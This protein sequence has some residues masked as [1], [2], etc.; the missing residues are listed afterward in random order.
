M[1]I[2]SI[3]DINL[4]EFQITDLSE[5]ERG[6]FHALNKL[7]KGSCFTI[8]RVST[9]NGLTGFYEKPEKARI[10]NPNLITISTVTG[11]AFLQ[12]Y[13][14]IAT[15]NVIICIPKNPLSVTSLIYIQTSINTVKWRYSYGR[16]PYKRILQKMKLFLPVNESDE[17]DEDII[18][19]IVKNSPYWEAFEKIIQ[20]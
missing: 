2:K 20:K 11:D 17:L 6:D 8:S 14:F 12:F 16:Q 19:K 3:P 18:S 10:L 9:D 5:L 7:D 13:P 1:T 15:D 4:R